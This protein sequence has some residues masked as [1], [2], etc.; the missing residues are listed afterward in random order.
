MSSHSSDCVEIFPDAKK[1]SSSVDLERLA[2]EINLASSEH[3]LPARTE[4]FIFRSS[5]EGYAV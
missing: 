5:T 4:G 1:L 3:V 2:Q